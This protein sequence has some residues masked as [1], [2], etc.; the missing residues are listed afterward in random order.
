M[1]KKEPAGFWSQLNVITITW[2]FYCVFSSGCCP[3]GSLSQCL[4]F[5]SM[6]TMA[7]TFPS[8]HPRLVTEQDTA[9]GFLSSV[10]KSC[11]QTLSVSNWSVARCFI[12][13]TEIGCSCGVPLHLSA[14]AWCWA[15]W[16]L[17]NF[18]RIHVGGRHNMAE[19]YGQREAHKTWIMNSLNRV[20]PYLVG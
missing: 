19:W 8:E 10:C 14:M 18:P 4:D 12:F 1:P 11:N 6:K 13:K 5:S 9:S 15:T 16:R 7:K 3:D 2:L 20:L 17:E